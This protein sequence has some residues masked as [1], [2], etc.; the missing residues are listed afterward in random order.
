MG[1]R[2][3]FATTTNGIPGQT[4]IVEANMIYDISQPID[5]NLKVWPG[6]TPPIREVLSDMKRG[7]NITLSTLRA[8]DAR[9][10][11]Y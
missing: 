8:T 11:F 5:E 4:P 10:F 2:L 1:E 9:H 7:D 6:D 3:P